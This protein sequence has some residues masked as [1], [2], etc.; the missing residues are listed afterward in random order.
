MTAKKL[1]KKWL[2]ICD[3]LTWQTVGTGMVTAEGDEML[4]ERCRSCK[5]AAAYLT[6]RVL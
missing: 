2:G 4:I 3:H 1:I 5:M 6:N